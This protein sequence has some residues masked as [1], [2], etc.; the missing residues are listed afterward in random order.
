MSGFQKTSIHKGI[1]GEDK[2]SALFVEVFVEPIP[3]VPVFDERL[4]IIVD[5][6]HNITGRHNRF[7]AMDSDNSGYVVV[8]LVSAVKGKDDDI[9]AGCFVCG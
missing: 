1:S 3:A 6:A 2:D 8:G 7:A 5:I 9:S 4:I